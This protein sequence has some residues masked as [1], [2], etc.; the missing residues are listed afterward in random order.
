MIRIPARDLEALRSN[1]RGYLNDVSTKRERQKIL[2]AGGRI[3]RTAASR[4]IKPAAKKH[5]YYSKAGKIEVVPGNLKRSMYA[6]KTRLKT[7]EVGPR[8]IRKIAGKYDKIGDTPKTSSGYYA[9]M[10]F[11]KASN[12]RRQVTESALST[13]AE[14]IDTAMQKALTRVHKTWKK[15]YNL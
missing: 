3:L 2:L 1:L 11:K 10:L 14:R 5:F 8:V 12:F 15:K 13:A 7:V 6:F 9:A 4:N